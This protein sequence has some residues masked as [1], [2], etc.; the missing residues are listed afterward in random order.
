MAL[1]LPQLLVAQCLHGGVKVGV[2]NTESLLKLSNLDW[3]TAR[4]GIKRARRA[5]VL[6]DEVAADGSGFEELKIS[7]LN[8]GNAAKRVLFLDVDGILEQRVRVSCMK[9]RGKTFGRLQLRTFCSPF[10]RLI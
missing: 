4:D 2:V 8:D 7:I 3:V 1:L 10:M 9:M 6:G 5:A